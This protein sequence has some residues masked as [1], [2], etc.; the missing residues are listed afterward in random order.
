M[1]G[2][3]DVTQVAGVIAGTVLGPVGKF[4]YKVNAISR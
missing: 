1:Q 2:L 3:A 4:A